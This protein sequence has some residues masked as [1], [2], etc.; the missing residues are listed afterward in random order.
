M[1]RHILVVQSDPL[2]GQHDEFNEW[3]DAEHLPAVLDVPG[4]VSA[5]RFRAAPSVHGEEP[6]H[7]YLAIYEIES[8]DL[9]QTLA[10]LSAAA[11]RM[12]I[13]DAFDKA[14]HETYAFTQIS[15]APTG[16]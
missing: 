1:P 13:H 2:E 8:D 4:F 14:N 12:H 7:E 16:P 11:R 5:R 9:A 3:Y 15:S 10:D 6:A